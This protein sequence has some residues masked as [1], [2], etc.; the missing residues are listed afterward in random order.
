MSYT[1]QIGSPGTPDD[2]K[3]SIHLLSSF[4]ASFVLQTL[5]GEREKLMRR[6]LQDPIERLGLHE[7]CNPYDWLVQTV[8][9]GVAFQG[10]GGFPK[11][12]SY[13]FGKIVSYHGH[14]L[15]FDHSHRNSR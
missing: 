14:E 10:N 15:S 4:Y 1:V 2:C 11:R 9:V 6:N 13:R 12:E 5:V 7:K 8:A 3:P